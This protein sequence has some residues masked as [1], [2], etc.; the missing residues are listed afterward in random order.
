[1]YTTIDQDRPHQKRWRQLGVSLQKQRP[2]GAQVSK[3]PS[4]GFLHPLF[5][6][7]PFPDCG[8]PPPPAHAQ[9]STGMGIE[10][11]EITRQSLEEV[12]IDDRGKKK[13]KHNKKSDRRRKVG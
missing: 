6:P 10:L 2:R 7:R 13:R 12:Y 4:A 9:S 8:G 5:G 1:V 11:T 3:P